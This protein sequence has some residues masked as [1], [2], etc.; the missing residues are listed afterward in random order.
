MLVYK[1]MTAHKTLLQF[2]KLV[3]LPI[4]VI[5]AGTVFVFS[6]LFYLQLTK[7]SVTGNPSLYDPLRNYS[8]FNTLPTQGSV[9]GQ[10]ITLS[11]QRPVILREF[12][13]HYHS[14]LAPYAE[15]FIDSA[16]EY[17]LPWTLLP[18]IAGKE[19][20]FGKVTPYGSFN[21]WGWGVWTNQVQG[22]NFSSW[23]EGVQKVAQ[24]LRKDYFDKGLDKLEEI[25]AKYTP[26]SANSH[27]GW[28]EGVEY[29]QWELEN[30]L[31]F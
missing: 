21:A 9:L 2:V 4:W 14:P 3:I 28:M 27:H 15:N 26:L 1:N 29:F 17:E 19:S 7:V 12:L 8:L 23:E 31:R 18:A 22:A 5:S 20:G 30:W 6:A 24:G 25:E 11:D 10:S 13:E 16:D